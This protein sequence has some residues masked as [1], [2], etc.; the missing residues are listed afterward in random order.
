[1]LKLYESCLR[2]VPMENTVLG[3]DCC[4]R[5]PFAGFVDVI[6]ACGCV[7]LV[8]LN[9]QNRYAFRQCCPD[10]PWH[11]SCPIPSFHKAVT[12]SRMCLTVQDSWLLFFM[13]SLTDFFCF[14]QHHGSKG[15]ANRITC[16]LDL[17]ISQ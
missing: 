1:M 7:C 11:A 16:E 8:I 12:A 6:A 3:A 5:N 10:G 4:L 17:P 9:H 2:G 13:C 14:L 15:E